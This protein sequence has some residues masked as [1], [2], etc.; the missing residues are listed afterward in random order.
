MNK[1][2]LHYLFCLAVLSSCRNAASSSHVTSMEDSIVA[3]NEIPAKT[4]VSDLD[5]SMVA[6]KTFPTLSLEDAISGTTLITLPIMY[7]GSGR[8]VRKPA[9]SCGAG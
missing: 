4:T 1:R 5:S 7:G 6:L 3:A 8:R 9:N 2:L